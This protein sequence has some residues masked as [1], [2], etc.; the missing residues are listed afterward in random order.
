MHTS[1]NKTD[2][3]INAPTP[4]NVLELKSFL[5]LVNYYSTFIRNISHKLHPLHVLLKKQCSWFWSADQERSFRLIKKEL[6]TLPVLMH[7]DP[8]GLY[9]INGSSRPIACASWTLS[10]AEKR[11]TQIEALAIIFTLKKFHDYLYGRP[12]TT[13]CDYQPLV[14]IFCEKKGIPV[15]AASRL[16]R[17]SVIL[18]S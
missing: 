2:T 15:Y 1:K 3:I 8:G 17:W 7:Y 6:S 11:Y 13:L 12:F 14:N 4:C 10:P 5:G 9:L 18:S 16:R